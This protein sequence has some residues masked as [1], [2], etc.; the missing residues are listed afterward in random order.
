MELLSE[1]SEEKYERG[2]LSVVQVI[3]LSPL[4]GSALIRPLRHGR[5]GCPAPGA[6]SALP[7]HTGFEELRLQGPPR[8]EHNCCNHRCSLGKVKTSTR[9]TCPWLYLWHQNVTPL[10]FLKDLPL[11]GPCPWRMVSALPLP[12]PSFPASC[13]C[14]CPTCLVLSHCLFVSFVTSH[15]RPADDRPGVAADFLETRISVGWLFKKM[16]WL[17]YRILSS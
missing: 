6:G 3:E 13:L 15:S 9:R 10:C 2:K 17:K 1:I 7:W 16:Y 11:G 8:T 14:L 12:S 4:S 5:E